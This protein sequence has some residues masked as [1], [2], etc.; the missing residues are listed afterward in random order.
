M[1]AY[2]KANDTIYDHLSTIDRSL[3]I[4]NVISQNRKIESTPS[5]S[6]CKLGFSW[7]NEITKDPPSKQLYFPSRI[8]SAIVQSYPLTSNL[9]T[10]K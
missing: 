4:I 1:N 3:K 10:I 2:F 7:P 9:G 5:V 6:D 8:H